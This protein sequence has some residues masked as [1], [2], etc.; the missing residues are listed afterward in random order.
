MDSVHVDTP[1][2]TPANRIVRPGV[3]GK[4]QDSG[5]VSYYS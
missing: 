1:G 2:S 5:V 3:C 4:I